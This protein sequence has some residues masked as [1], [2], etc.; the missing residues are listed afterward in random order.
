MSPGG[1][2]GKSAKSNNSPG[3][4]WMSTRGVKY[5]LLRVGSTPWWGVWVVMLFSAIVFS[6]CK[7]RQAA[8]CRLEIEIAR[9]HASREPRAR[10]QMIAVV[11]LGGLGRLDVDLP[12]A[13][14][15]VLGQANR[16]HAMLEAR[17]DLVLVHRE[18]QGDG[19]D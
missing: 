10:R 3:V 12:R 8:G 18:G 5:L 6:L 11:S 1:T 19:S 9:T 15:L 17:L 7:W 4:S 2:P 16:Q 13:S 14:G